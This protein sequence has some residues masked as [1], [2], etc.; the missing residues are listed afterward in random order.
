[1]TFEICML[2][3]QAHLKLELETRASLGIHAFEHP[4]FDSSYG[5]VVY[6]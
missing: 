5:N 4:Y 2:E 3:Y 1:M 6:L